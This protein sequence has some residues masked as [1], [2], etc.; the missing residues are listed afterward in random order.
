MNNRLSFYTRFT[1][2]ASFSLFFKGSE[3]V[4]AK[5][6]VLESSTLSMEKY[7]MEILLLL[8]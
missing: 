4:N 3:L 5:L 8:D 7:P 6:K 2:E 1:S